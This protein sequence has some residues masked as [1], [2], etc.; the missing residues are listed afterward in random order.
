MNLRDRI[1]QV[2]KEHPD[3]LTVRELA[4]KME[5]SQSDL[6]HSLIKMSYKGRVDKDADERWK[7]Q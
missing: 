6:E 7:V 2:L 3:G 1:E 4:E 5:W